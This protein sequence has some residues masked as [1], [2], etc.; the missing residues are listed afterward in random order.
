MP[1]YVHLLMPVVKKDHMDKQDMQS[2]LESMHAMLSKQAE[3]LSS[4]M[5]GGIN[6][7]NVGGGRGGGSGSGDGMGGVLNPPA[8]AAENTQSALHGGGGGGGGS[9][10]VTAA[11]T[12][13]AHGLTAPDGTPLNEVMGGMTPQEQIALIQVHTMRSLKDSETQLPAVLRQMDRLQR[14]VNNQEMR[15]EGVV[16]VLRDIENLLRNQA[17]VIIHQETRPPPRKGTILTEAELE[18]EVKRLLGKNDERL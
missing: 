18:L 10:D 15:L 1:P 3:V 6:I 12:Q 8:L 5:A 11:I 17:P 7:V 9:S 4:L 16:T 2:R 13:A 14:T